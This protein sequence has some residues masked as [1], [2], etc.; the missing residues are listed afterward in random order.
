MYC[1]SPL[2]RRFMKLVVK[3]YTL[4]YT[5]RHFS[6]ERMQL[7]QTIKNSGS[8]A[9]NCAELKFITKTLS[10]GGTTASTSLDNCL[11][12]KHVSPLAKFC[13]ITISNIPKDINEILSKYF[14]TPCIFKMNDSRILFIGMFFLI[15]ILFIGKWE[16]PCIS[17]VEDNLL[18]HNQFSSLL[19]WN[20][21]IRRYFQNT[22]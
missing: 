14:S 16:T 12:N 17:L 7:Q 22:Q 8:R 4:L 18:D 10:S 21:F 1:P 13:Y 3:L 20:L 2:N 15:F 6:R 5:N 19:M 11:F 9:E